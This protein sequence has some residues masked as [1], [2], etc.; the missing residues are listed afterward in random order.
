LPVM[1]AEWKVG[2]AQDQDQAVESS[3]GGWSRRAGCGV[4][5]APLF[6]GCNHVST[7]AEV[8][9]RSTCVWHCL[10]CFA[11]GVGAGC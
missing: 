8:Y 11:F 1:V 5:C 4:Q 9:G 2:G 7:A 10:Y 6:L 3:A